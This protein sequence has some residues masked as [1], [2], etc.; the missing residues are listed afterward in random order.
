MP[1]LLFP[2]DYVPAFESLAGVIASFVLGIFY[3][4][5]I[6][7]VMSLGGAIFWSGN[8]A[9]FTVLVKKKDDKNLLEI[10]E[11]PFEESK[12]EEPKEPEKKP[13]RAEK[14]EKEPEGT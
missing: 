9:I 12:K 11:E 5:V 8:T 10:K 13:K 4:F 14:K 3:Y 7:F 2:P 6:L 1:N